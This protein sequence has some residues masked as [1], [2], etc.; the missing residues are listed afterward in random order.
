M[1][2]ITITVA[3][4]AMLCSI[5]FMTPTQQD[6]GDALGATD[7]TVVKA[8]QGK[9]FS[10]DYHAT[11]AGYTKNEFN[12]A[13][14]QKKFGQPGFT[15]YP[16]EIYVPAG[17]YEVQVYY[18]RNLTSHRPQALYRVRHARGQVQ[19]QQD[20]AEQEALRGFNKNPELLYL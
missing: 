20:R 11:I 6:A 15:D 19:R 12:A 1:K 3:M 13:G 16:S 8:H 18:F 14:V 7:I 9:P 2:I 10:G 5:G 4:T 17:E